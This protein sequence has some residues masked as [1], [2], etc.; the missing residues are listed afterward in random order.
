M[1][2]LP[3][4]RGRASRVVR[5]QAEPGNERTKVTSSGKA[6]PRNLLVDRPAFA[7]AKDEMAV[8]GAAGELLQPA[9]GP[10]HLDPVHPL[11]PAQA[12]VHAH[13]AMG[14]IA[15]SGIDGTPEPT[16]TRHDR[17]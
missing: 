16:P 8:G 11:R 14:E 9:V 12:K 3:G 4:T 17:H 13:I 10:A 1:N 7:L 15:P 2:L 5:S 6:L